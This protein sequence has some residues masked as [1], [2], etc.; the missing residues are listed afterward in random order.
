MTQEVKFD[1]MNQKQDKPILCRYGED[2]RTIYGT[3]I[4]SD[5]EEHPVN[6][7][8]FTGI[9][10]QMYKPDGN[11]VIKDA[12]VSSGHVVIPIDEQMTASAGTGFMDLK[13][14]ASDG[15]IY[16]CH[17][18][19][20]IDTPVATDDIVASVS[21]IDGYVFP[22][23]FQLKLT[24][25]RNIYFTD[26][27][28]I[29]ARASSMI[30]GEGLTIEGDTVSIDSETLSKIEEVDD[31]QDILT[32][33][34]GIAINGN[35]ISSTS[36]GIE[37]EQIMSWSG[38]KNAGATHVIDSPITDYKLIVL[39]LVMDNTGTVV[40][41]IIFNPLSVR[42]TVQTAILWY[43]LNS[44]RNF[45]YSFADASTFTMNNSGVSGSTEFTINLYGLK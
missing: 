10:I 6:L 25:G 17:A 19:V 38:A 28:T 29:N 7:N 4:N 13:L 27:N 24:A 35:V 21:L 15:T 5:D 31:K 41:S 8:N 20:I 37:F 11:F 30:A 39:E 43:A 23:D 9:K 16:T 2:G 18:T 45:I 33:G 42:Y 36:Q 26:E 3:V 12:T 14:T 34:T 44:M 1:L 22:D 32:A 40:G